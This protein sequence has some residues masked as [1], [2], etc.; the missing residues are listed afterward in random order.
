MK[1]VDALGALAGV[2]C[3]TKGHWLPESLIPKLAVRC[4]KGLTPRIELKLES[5]IPE[6]GEKKA[7][8]PFFTNEKQV[9]EVHMKLSLKESVFLFR[10]SAPTSIKL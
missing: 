5:G 10:S 4:P 7:Q 9:R 2:V 6:R 3:R 1:E 8:K